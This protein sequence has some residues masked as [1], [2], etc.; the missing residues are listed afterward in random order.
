VFQTCRVCLSVQSTLLRGLK[1]EKKYPQSIAIKLRAV[2]SRM[3]N[4]TEIDRRHVSNKLSHVP[5]LH[6]HRTAESL[7]SF[8]PLASLLLLRF[9]IQTAASKSDH[10]FQQAQRGLLSEVSTSKVARFKRNGSLRIQS[11]EVPQIK[12]S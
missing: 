12:L 9:V 1:R 2:A 10:S 3:N 4:K 6:L 8:L 7:A 11:L 5:R